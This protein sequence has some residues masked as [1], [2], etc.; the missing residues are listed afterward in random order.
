MGSLTS[1][2]AEVLDISPEALEVANCYLQLQDLNKTAETLDMPTELVSQLLS[3]REVKAYID[4]VF[5]NLGF[6]NRFKMRS[7]M[8][9]I[10]TKKFQEMEESETG[11]SKDI[12]ELMALSH[13][14]TME[15]MSKQIE[16][17]KL[18]QTNIKSQVNV[19]INDGGSKYENLIQRLI[20]SAN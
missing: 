17:E 18:R 11:S 6:N 20:T 19:Q 1:S 5:F 2:P 16:L 14:M 9:A 13:K 15:E 7:A 8:D 10:L 12:A 3:K 4:N